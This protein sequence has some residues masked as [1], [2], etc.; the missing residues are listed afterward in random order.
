MT[1]QV[2]TI[3]IEGE[4][5][6]NVKK[7]FAD[8]EKQASGLGSTLKSVG[9]I[10]S[11]FLAANVV[12]GGVQA[13]T[14][15]V[16]DSIAAIK[17]SNIVNAQMEAVLKS[18]GAAAWASSKQLGTRAEAIEKNS[19]FEDEAIKKGQNL[20][21]TFTNITNAADG[22]SEVFNDATDIMV[23]MAQAMG[24]DVS[25]GAIQ[26]G[27]ALNDP[28]AGISALSRVGVTFTEQQKEQI[29]TMVEAGDVAGAQGVIL[30]ELNKE[31]GGSAKAA[32][33]AAGASEAYKDRM[34]D[35]QEVIGAKM[36]P[37]SEKLMEIKL[38][39]I[40]MIADKLI[41]IIEELYIKH[42][43]AVEAAIQSVVAFVQANWPTFQAVLAF[44]FDF[45][46]TKI[47]GFIQMIQGIVQVVSGVINLISAL[48]HGDWQAAW[49]AL[50]QIAEGIVNIF[51]GNLKYIF[52]NLPELLLAGL[53]GLGGAIW[54]IFNGILD[55][56]TTYL[57]NRVNEIIGLINGAISAYNSLPLAPN[58]GTV[59]YLQTPYAGAKDM[60]DVSPVGFAMGS[61]F[62]PR[63]MLA[64]LHRGEAVIPA[65]MNA[66]GGGGMGMTVN[67]GQIIAYDEVQARSSVGDI[68]W[69]LNSGLESRGVR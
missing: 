12:S 25:G 50:Q 52:G 60:D 9:T 33:D 21:L 23:D 36:L 46:K 48:F 15:F 27:K 45:V 30:A 19:L 10:A 49:A 64:F 59:Q 11:G 14:G 8:T 16:G 13:L 4:G 61:P 37:I 63:D 1:T 42:W 47:E 5:A 41:P 67:V 17:E 57:R 32:S 3:R 51:V 22:S 7:L 58:I 20:L 53:K 2:I 29:A 65:D 44:A 43:P 54:N 18:T 28:I 31:F 34:N 39:I 55:S 40:A 26:L 69:L 24:T 62:I 66:Y 35:L 38:K 56:V 68:A 6:D